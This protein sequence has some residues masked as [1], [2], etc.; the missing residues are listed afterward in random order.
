MSVTSGASIVNSG[1]VF[2]YD[3]SNTGRSWLGKPTTNTNN[4]FASLGNGLTVTYV[5]QDSQ[6]WQIYS[7]SGTWNS[8]T[9]PYSMVITSSSTFLGNIG[10][11]A[12]LQIYNTC[13]QKWGAWGGINYVN[14]VNMVNP[15]TSTVTTVQNYQV[16]KRENFIYS[17]G[18]A[19]PSG[20]SQF[21]YL[22]TQPISNGTTFNPSTDFVYVKNMQIEQNSFCTPYTQFS[23]ST[24]QALL[25][26]TGINT[27]T[28]TS[29]TYNSDNTFSYNGTSD[30]IECGLLSS[31]LGSNIT[32]STFARVSSIVSKN[33]L[34]SLNGAYNFFLPGNRLTTT[35]QLYWDS[36][37]GWKNG[38]TTSWNV[39][40]WY[41]L[42]WT[43]SGT[44]LTFYVNGVNDGT[45]SIAA[46]IVPSSA[47]RIG[48]ANAGEYATGSIGAVQVYNRALSAAEVAQNFNAQRS[49]Y[50]I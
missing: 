29:L 30:Y 20:T 34:L 48:L 22:I 21:G 44:T 4:G 8:G 11:S 23:R 18:Y 50:G 41:N 36:A 17:S 32:V 2:N 16:W 40:Q 38:N 5:G 31:S 24:T 7:L 26:L 13:P 33:N 12:Q 49:L 39:G 9:Y 1:L 42:T 19:G 43:I 28:A 25:D 3:M 35:Y 27:V 47:S 15:G 45:T 37:S 46:N 6:G 14:D 10:Y